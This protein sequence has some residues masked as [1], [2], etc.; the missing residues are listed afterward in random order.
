MPVAGDRPTLA[1]ISRLVSGT[2]GHPQIVLPFL[3]S[4]IAGYAG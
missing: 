3:Q 1:N 4:A 2:F